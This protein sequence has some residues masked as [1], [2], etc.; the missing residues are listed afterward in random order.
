RSGAMVAIRRSVS[1]LLMM[2]ASTCPALASDAEVCFNDLAMLRQ[3]PAA[4]AQACEALARQ[5]DAK[6]QNQLGVMH[7]EGWILPKDEAAAAD[8]YHKSARQGFVVAQANLAFV[9]L[10][11]LGVPRDYEQAYIWATLAADTGNERAAR[12][13]SA[14]LGHL[15]VQEL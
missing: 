15:R 3:E 5:G 2:I 11:G 1:A 14:A 7:A 4:I 12:L 10:W 13:V 9:Y 8:W 6:A